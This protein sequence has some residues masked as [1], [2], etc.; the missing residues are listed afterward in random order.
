M[1]VAKSA[2]VALI[3]AGACTHSIPAPAPLP[4]PTQPQEQSMSRTDMLDTVPVAGL[5]TN[6]SSRKGTLMMK[7]LLWLYDS[8]LVLRFNPP[9]VYNKLLEEVVLCSGITRKGSPRF[10]IAP[11]VPL[12]DAEGYVG[13]YIG[14]EHQVI[15]FA[16]G[17]EVKAVS[18]R[19]GETTYS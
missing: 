8:V 18:R 7:N 17:Y 5:T 13:Y 1:S 2:L 14:G 9:D 19:I 15:V 12:S 16:L 4:V 6:L 11:I 10:Y 3:F